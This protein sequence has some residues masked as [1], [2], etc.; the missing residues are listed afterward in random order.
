MPV[1]LV[2]FATDNILGKKTS[3][4]KRRFKKYV[5]GLPADNLFSTA[6]KV[7]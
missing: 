2:G 7:S 5:A 6:P 1:F 4:R 3:S